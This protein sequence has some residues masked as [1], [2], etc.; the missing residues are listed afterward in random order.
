MPMID[1]QHVVGAASARAVLG[2]G[3]VHVRRLEHEEPGERIRLRRVL[4]VHPEVVRVGGLVVVPEALEG[5][6]HPRE[7]PG[8]PVL[9]GV[10]PVPVVAAVG[11]EPAGPRREVDDHGDRHE[12]QERH[13]PLLQ[14]G[15]GEP[16]RHAGA[17]AGERVDHDE[18]DPERREEPHARPL[19]GA[20]GAEGDARGDHPRPASR[21]PGRSGGR[22]RAPRASPSRRS[23]S[24]RGLAAVEE[25]EPEPE[26]REQHDPVVEQGDPRHHDRVAVDREE[27]RGDHGHD[28]RRPEPAGD[29]REQE[30]RG[31]A[32]ERRGRAPP[33]RVCRRRTRPCR[34]RSSTCRAAGARRRRARRGRCRCRRG[35]KSASAPSG[36]LDS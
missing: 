12:Q 34:A 31:G 15:A 7:E 17:P 18:V 19:H 29:E 26:Q 10:G 32:R 22:A 30:H 13:R 5:R 3:E 11:D 27:E 6:R 20:R 14:H 25:H 23:S 36:Q 35:A 28:R 9:G 16:E 21:W 4:G 33:E 2:G 24:R 1:S 8:G